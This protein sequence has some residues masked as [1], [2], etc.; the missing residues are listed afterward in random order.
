MSTHAPA[1]EAV[2]E[3][4]AAT[5]TLRLRAQRRADG[6]T[7]AAGQYSSGALR[8]LRPHYPDDSGQAVITVVN[9]GGG[10]LG[11][12]RYEMTYDG[13][14]HS[15]V[16]LTTQSA[17]KIYRTPQ[18]PASQYQ[19][20]KLSADALLES[21]PDQLIA[22]RDA[23]F[24]QRTDVELDPQ[25]SYFAAEIVTP[26]WSP[27]SKQFT[28]GEVRLQ[29]RIR[30]G[31]VPLLWDNLVL[32]PDTADP[33]GLGW[34]EGRTHCASVVAAGP[35]VD[36]NCLDLIR[37]C[38]DAFTDVHVGVSLLHAPAL[39]LRALGNDTGT[40]NELVTQV[41]ALLRA[42]AWPSDAPARWDLRKY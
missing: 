4:P 15:A 6:R 13:D 1:I 23:H 42:E 30:C 32:R 18:G 21:V 33:L 12:D 40:L 24:I 3:R 35:G 22:Y 2:E 27:D 16:L 28:Y 41:G 19:R 38:A 20:I 9:P 37:D 7:V 5:G 17:T 25:A 10:Y 34:L 14:P 8:V 39:V 26:G 31:G 11:A 29:N 36:R